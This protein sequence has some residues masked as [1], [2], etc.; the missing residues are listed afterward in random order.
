MPRPPGHGFE[1]KARTVIVHNP[2]S[3]I[4]HVATRI[5]DGPR[6]TAESCNLDDADVLVE[7]SSLGELYRQADPEPELCAICVLSSVT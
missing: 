4:A 6:M 5:G 2:S 7:Y 1:L 3:N